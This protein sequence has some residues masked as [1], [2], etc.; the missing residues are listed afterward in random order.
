MNRLKYGIMLVCMTVLFLSGPLPVSAQENQP[1]R[2]DVSQAAVGAEEITVYVV[3]DY[4]EGLSA[5]QFSVSYDPAV[6]EPAGAD[7]GGYSFTGGYTD[8]YT[9]GL[10]SC[11]KKSDG[12]LVFAGARTGAQ[13]YTGNA[14]VIRFRVCSQTAVR[15]ELKL[16]VETAAVETAQGIEKIDPAQPQTN[17]SIILQKLI[18]DVNQDGQVTLPDAQLTLKAALKLVALTPEQNELADVDG[19]GSVELADAQLILKK[20]LKLIP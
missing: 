10:L 18:G 12:L 2:L 16:T 3:Q 11:N 17:Y 7:D 19:S 4:T 6:L 1:F 5:F 13:A 14:A 8:S 20:A 15:T 9:D